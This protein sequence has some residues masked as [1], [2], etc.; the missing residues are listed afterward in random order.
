MN[1]LSTDAINY[2]LV[3]YIIQD[4]VYAVFDDY[5][6]DKYWPPYFS[7]NTAF[8]TQDM[9][10]RTISFYEPERFLMLLYLENH[11]SYTDR[12]EKLLPTLRSTKQVFRTKEHYYD[13]LHDRFL[14]AQKEICNKSLT[15]D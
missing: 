12:H 15:T 8:N 14:N 9:I 11:Q 5:L 13:F 10:N 6:A 4:N 1:N 3:G 2:A 7:K